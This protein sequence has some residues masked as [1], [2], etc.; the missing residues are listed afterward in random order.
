MRMYFLSC[1]IHLSLI[2]IFFRHVVLPLPIPVALDIPAS[3]SALS[4][5]S[6]SIPSSGARQVE[7]SSHSNPSSETVPAKTS[8]SSLQNAR[9]KHSSR[10]PG[11]LSDYHCSFTQISQSPSS[12]KSLLLLILSLLPYHI[13]NSVFP[14]RILSFIYQLSQNPRPL[15]KPLYLSN[16]QKPWMWNLN[17]CNLTKHGV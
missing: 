3:P 11:Y 9:P 7:S 4:S 17:L 12:S 1:L 16:G 15:S 13:L 14:F 5:P 10:V 6:A 8:V 2:L